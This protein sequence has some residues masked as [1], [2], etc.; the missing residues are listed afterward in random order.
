MFSWRKQILRDGIQS[1]FSSEI[2]R[3]QI[4]EADPIVC[5]TH[6]AICFDFMNGRE[7]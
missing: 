1:F 6:G 5:G 2:D 4:D 7:S 3:F